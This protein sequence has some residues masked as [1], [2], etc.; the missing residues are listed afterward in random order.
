MTRSCPWCGF[1]CGKKRKKKCL[2]RMMQHLAEISR[3]SRSS[4]FPPSRLS[5]KSFL[6]YFP[7]FSR[8]ILR[9][10]SFLLSRRRIPPY[11]RIML[12]WSV[13]SLLNYICSQWDVIAVGL[14]THA[15]LLERRGIRRDIQALSIRADRHS[16]SHIMNSVETLCSWGIRFSKKN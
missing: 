2:E 3:D 1:A 10:L 16:L 9:F 7:S 11:R 4:L 8:Y 13:V 14:L 12:L 15:G 5:F 6:L